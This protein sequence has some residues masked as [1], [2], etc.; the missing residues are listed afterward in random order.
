MT[1][2]ALVL[3]AVLAVGAMGLVACGGDDDDDS[4]SAGASTTVDAKDLEDAAKAAGVD[5]ECL[6]GVQA[7]SQMAASGGAAFGGGASELEKSI[8]AFEAY[9][10]AAPKDIRADVGVLADAYASFYRAIAD[11]GWDPTSGEQPSAEQMQA[12]SSASEK[13]DTTDVKDAGDR[14]SAYFDEHC[15]G[16]SGD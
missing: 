6:A 2:R 13:L 16:S 1:K 15:K 4:A 3:L 5:K 10:K 8:K 9:A 12:I 7:Y 14:V 11:S